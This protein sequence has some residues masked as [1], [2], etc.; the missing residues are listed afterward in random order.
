VVDSPTG[1]D[2]LLA[3]TAISA[4]GLAAGTAIYRM[5]YQ[6]AEEAKRLDRQL[7]HDR[8]LREVDELL[9][10]LDDAI[11]AA[12]SVS[13]AIMTCKACAIH[14]ADRIEEELDS[15][16]DHFARLKREASRLVLRYGSDHKLVQLYLELL[17]STVDAFGAIDEADLP[18]KESQLEVAEEKQQEV[19]VRLREFVDECQVQ[20]G[21][22]APSVAT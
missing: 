18:L 1:G 7:E 19:R 17:T 5:R 20:V 10:T 12:N 6:L 4:A 9:Q 2:I 3:G 8:H 21:I 11:A 15:Q 14:S 22:R 13:D 16:T